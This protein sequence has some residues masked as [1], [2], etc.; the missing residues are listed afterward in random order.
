MN[1]INFTQKWLQA[2]EKYDD[3]ARSLIL[4]NYYNKNKKIFENI[5]DIGCG[6]GS[7]LRWMSK[8]DFSFNKMLMI[9]K[10]TKL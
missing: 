6:T 9:D 2:R 7:F 8:Y 5:I 4:D 10:D 3:N 1:E